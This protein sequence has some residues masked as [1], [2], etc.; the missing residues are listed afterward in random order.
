MGLLDKWIGRKETKGQHVDPVCHMTVDPA[1]AAGRSRHGGQTIY[2]CSGAC[3]TRFDASP[4]KYL[5]A[6]GP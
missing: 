2:F 3:K 6:R 5:G 1:T 4:G